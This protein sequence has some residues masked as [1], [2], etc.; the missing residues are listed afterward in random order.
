MIVNDI[1]NDI[2]GYNM[3]IYNVRLFF[4]RFKSYKLLGD[5]II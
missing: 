1:V 5:F 2:Y 3:Y 4:S